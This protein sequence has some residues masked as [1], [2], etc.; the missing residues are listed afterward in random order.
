[1]LHLASTTPRSWVDRVSADLDEL[2]LDHTHCEK[3]AAS[4]ALNL[5]FR[6]DATFPHLAAPLAAVAREELEHFERLL[7]LLAD[8]GVAFRAVT[9]G[10]YAARLLGGA[11]SGG[12]A[13]TVDTLLCAALIEARSCERMTRLAEYLPEVGL[14]NFYRDLLQSEARHFS[15]YVD[16]ARSLP[17][18][19]DAAVEERVRELA[20]HEADVLA[21]VPAAPRMHG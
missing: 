11:R 20:A 1:M 12:L 6:H 17:G 16:M 15:L 19:K 21:N 9:P 8:R 18:V 13:R 7:E 14:R 10:P 2:L 4:T 5:V 3:K